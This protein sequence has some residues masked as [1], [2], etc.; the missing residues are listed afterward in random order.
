MVTGL[1][2]FKNYFHGFEDCYLII[3]GTACDIVIQNRGFF[4]RATQDID[5]IL[6]IE[7]LSTDFVKQFWKFI[8]DGKYG[9][10]QK[11]QVNRNCYR[12][13][14]PEK[15]D[16]PLQ[17]ELFCKAPDAISLQ[18]EAHLTPI[19]T[20]EGMSHLSAILINDDY[21]H[22]TIAH[23]SF[24]DNI[25][26]ANTEALICLKA[27]ACLDNKKRKETGQPIRTREVVK[28][29]NDVFRMVFMLNPDDR[30]PLPAKIM[31]DLQHFADAVK[32]DLPPPE[33]FR[34]NGFGRQS[35]Q[36]IYTNFIQ[37]FGLNPD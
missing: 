3:G 34:M 8:A 23:S 7:A 5:I 2:I 35:M 16:F 26:Y 28:H 36:T 9:V 4:P 33:I 24:I 21:Y 15:S 10:K 27:F 11:D 1:E 18:N 22:F 19:P 32:N 30:F 20:D 13:Q 31:D 25:H 29:K 37:I 17:I 12:F 14:N 6:I